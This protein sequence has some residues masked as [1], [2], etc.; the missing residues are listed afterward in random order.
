MADATQTA[1]QTPKS[2]LESKTFW[3]MI[4]ILVSPML[5]KNGIHIGDATLAADD[6]S[7]LIGAALT[8]Y[9]RFSASSPVTLL[10]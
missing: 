3:G 6:I 7:K 1:T 4:L 10:K 5:A 9:G 8:L 2:I